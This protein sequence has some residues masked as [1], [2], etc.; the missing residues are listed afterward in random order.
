MVIIEKSSEYNVRAIKNPDFK[1]KT[2]GYNF[3][4]PVMNS[5]EISNLFISGG[6]VE[7]AMN[8]QSKSTWFVDE[9]ISTLTITQKN[10]EQKYTID[11]PEEL[12]EAILTYFDANRAEI[13]KKSLDTNLKKSQSK[14][15]N[16]NAKKGTQEE[17]ADSTPQAFTSASNNTYYEDDYKLPIAQNIISPKRGC[18]EYLD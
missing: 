4:Y 14:I 18:S 9:K 10:N 16:Q 2:H 8:G 3:S 11:N 13:L 17:L 12:G 1:N 7:V 5:I 15:G 6:S